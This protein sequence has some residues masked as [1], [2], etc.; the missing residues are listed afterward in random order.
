MRIIIAIF[1][2]ALVSGCSTIGIS[3]DTEYGK[4]SY[5]LPE[6]KGTKK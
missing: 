2:L 3:I 4:F 6:P 1:A 5:I